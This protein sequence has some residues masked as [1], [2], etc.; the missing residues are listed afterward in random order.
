M[1]TNVMFI[2]LAVLLGGCSIWKP[3]EAPRSGL[4]LMRLELPT[5][6]VDV[7]TFENKGGTR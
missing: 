3:L 1:K 6:N 5:M 7:L 4:S 2:I